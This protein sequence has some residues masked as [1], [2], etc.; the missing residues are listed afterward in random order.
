M[1]K[2]FVFRINDSDHFDTIRNEILRGYLRQGWGAQGMSVNNSYEEYKAAWYEKWGENDT[3]EARIKRKYNNLRNMIYIEKG[4]IIIIPKVSINDGYDYPCRCFTVARCT[5]TYSFEV[6]K[7]IN[8]FGHIIGIESLFSCPYY[9]NDPSNQITAKFRAYQSSINNVW[10][11]SFCN[12]VDEL[13]KI[14]NDKGINVDEVTPN[15]LCVVS[16]VINEKYDELI[17]VII[18]KVSKYTPKQF[19][20]IIN[21]LFQKNGYI[22]YKQN[23]HDGR[24]GD[25][26]I[27]LKYDDKTLL[28][29]IFKSS[30]STE[31][32][33]INIQA[34]KKPGT[35]L[36]DINAVK[37]LID[38]A[39]T[40]NRENTND[41]NIVIDL[42]DEFQEATVEYAREHNVILI[43]GR[44]FASLLIQ[45]GLNGEI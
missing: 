4:D 25:I 35:D 34:K 19:E 43:N 3:T 9:I 23:V 21:E 1:S 42:A 38:L 27:S 11:K 12:S 17:D 45:F 36:E 5:E 39:K 26:D 44:Q 30:E 16:E 18:D 33:Y 20:N 8:D 32:P 29:N 15:M 2:Y 10:N 7:S 28:G 41:I 40:H 14:Y 22:F 6:M 24:G 37:Q 13:I 31:T